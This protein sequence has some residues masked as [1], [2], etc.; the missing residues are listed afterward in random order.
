MDI[1]EPLKIERF[2]IEKPETPKKS[3]SVAK[4]DTPSQ[5]PAEDKAK[6]KTQQKVATKQTT[7]NQQVTSKTS[8][9][10][11]SSLDAQGLPE[12][13]V[14]QVGSFQ[15]KVNAQQLQKKLVAKDLPAYVKDFNL[16]EGIRYRVLIGPKL[17]KERA[18]KLSKVVEKEHALISKIVRY[19]PGFEE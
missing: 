3:P 8:Q 16:P 12:A 4:Q 13:W 14:L 15:D 9:K 5:K 11:M 2:E 6:N 7:S 17:S 18:A 1:P 10:T 19:K